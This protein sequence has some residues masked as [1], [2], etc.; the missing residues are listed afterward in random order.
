MK[1]H[2]QTDILPE[3][4]MSHSNDNLQKCFPC[5]LHHHSEVQNISMPGYLFLK[6]ELSLP[7]YRMDSPLH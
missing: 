5:I 3:H 7:I 6:T 4:G 1:V 2:T